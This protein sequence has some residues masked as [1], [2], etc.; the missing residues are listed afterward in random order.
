[1]R[2]RRLCEKNNIKVVVFMVALPSTVRLSLLHRLGVRTL[3]TE[4][5]GFAPQHRDGLAKKSVKY[6]MRRSFAVNRT[7]CTWLTRRPSNA[8]CWTTP[9]SRQT[10]SR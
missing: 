4:D 5:D 9:C 10:G 7:T 8:S 6:L 1:M 3:N 2:P